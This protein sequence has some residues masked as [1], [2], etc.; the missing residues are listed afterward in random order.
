[1][2][3]YE[4]NSLLINQRSEYTWNNGTF[5]GTRSVDRFKINLYYT[6][7]F[8]AEIWYDTIDNKIENVKSFKSKAALDPYLDLITINI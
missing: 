7:E 6:K 3:L 2:T 1:M 5:I 8:F 4:F